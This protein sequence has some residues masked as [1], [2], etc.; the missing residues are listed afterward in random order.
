MNFEIFWSIFIGS[1]LYC[2]PQISGNDDT[3]KEIC[4]FVNTV[5]LR[6]HKKFVDGTYAYDEILIPPEQQAYFDY[7]LRFQGEKV[8]V[9]K[10]LRGCAC[11]RRPCAKLCCPRDQFF[12]KASKRCEKITTDMKISWEVEILLN[13][14]SVKNVNI[15]EKFTTQIGLPCNDLEAI[16]P[17]RDKFLLKDNGNLSVEAEDGDKI[18]LNSLSYCYSPQLDT[19]INTHKL[20]PYSCYHSVENDW[21]FYLDAWK[22]RTFCGS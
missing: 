17:S 2:L 14:N 3:S 12:S 7:E 6:G 8:K 22:R 4:D 21:K 15:L 19:S 13:T 11:K 18:I 1:L 16:D 10:H 20:I 5:D 9:P